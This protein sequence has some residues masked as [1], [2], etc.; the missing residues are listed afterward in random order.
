[1]LHALGK[2]Y[3][4]FSYFSRGADASV[5]AQYCIVHVSSTN[6]ELQINNSRQLPAA[7][8]E[9][10]STFNINFCEEPLGCCI[11]F[12]VAQRGNLC[13]TACRCGTKLIRQ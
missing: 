8:V 1:M 10:S 3:L 13:K 11:F 12:T 5:N 7:F 2:A 9:P 4:F 6:Q